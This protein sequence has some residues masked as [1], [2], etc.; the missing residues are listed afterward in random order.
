LAGAPGR[1]FA[2]NDDRTL[3]LSEDGRDGTW[4]EIDRLHAAVE[5]TATARASNAPA[6]LYVL[7]LDG[8]LWRGTVAP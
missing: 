6:T 1:I 2:L 7:H 5:I 8:T 4:R 3:W